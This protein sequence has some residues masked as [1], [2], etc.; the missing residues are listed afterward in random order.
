MVYHIIAIEQA[1]WRSLQWLHSPDHVPYLYLPNKAVQ[2]YNKTNSVLALGSAMG[3]RM[4]GPTGAPGDFVYRD[5][6]ISFLIVRAWDD[7][8]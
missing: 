2:E 1:Q 7:N 4:T 3:L 8:C 6:P 5:V